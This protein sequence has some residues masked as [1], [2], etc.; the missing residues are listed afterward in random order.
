MGDT[1]ITLEDVTAALSQHEGTTLEFKESKEHLSKEFWKTYSSFANTHGG[2][3]LFGIGEDD[4]K[5]AV[6][7]GVSDPDVQ[8]TE[9]FSTLSNPNK[10]SVDLIH[11]DDVQVFTIQGKSV[12]AVYVHEAQLNQKPV[13]LNGSLSSTFIRKHETDCRASREEL[14]AMLRNQSDDL[15]SELLNGYS[16]D[17]LD[18]TSIANYQ[19]R[20]SNRYPE[21]NFP[22]M[23]PFDFLRNIGVF[24]IDHNDHST[25]KLTLG[26]LLFF[27]KYNSIR[28]RIHH[29][30]V[31]F[32]DKRGTGERWTDRVH[33]GDLA[34][35]NMNLFN[36]YAIVMDKLLASINRPFMLDDKM[37][38]KSYADLG[39][40][41]REAFVNMI[42]H[43]DYLSDST[44][45][46]VEIHNP[47]YLFI[48]PGIMKIPADSF[49][50]GAN[51]RPRNHILVQLFSQMGAAERAGSGSQK[52]RDVVEKNDFKV[53][54]IQTS[55]EKTTFKL[56]VATVID[57]TPGLGD[58]EKDIYQI[59]NENY[60][61]GVSMS[62]HEI[63]EQ[64]P[65]YSHSRIM[66]AL[67]TLY[68]KELIIKLGGNR[69][70]TYT[71]KISTLELIRN[72]ERTSTALKN[73][74]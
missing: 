30:F 62:A 14:S 44:S 53:P 2:L 15:D 61:N 40:A 72:F 48:N 38:R 63:E 34:F 28:D 31:D 36:Y 29:Y 5:N 59:L 21:R 27:G 47:Y 39:I 4:E 68:E 43:A 49:F 35:P 16:I 50:K 17:D 71:K 70:R 9:L 64:L 24:Q 66:R 32:Q 33:S 41:L 51:S 1:M 6:V 56:W 46:I 67:R 7:I 73:M 12:L 13:Y 22:S 8:R 69:N 45:L 60:D 18:M 25:P 23:S 65:Q 54:D 74:F 42:V 58:V 3:V 37:E 11:S 10:V 20:L 26:G 57:V 52:I 19:A 55:L